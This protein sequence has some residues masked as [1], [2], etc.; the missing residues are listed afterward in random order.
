LGTYRTPLAV[1]AIS[2]ENI[3]AA[4][5][6]GAILHWDG[7]KWQS[8]PNPYTDNVRVQLR[9]IKALTEK[10]IWVVGSYESGEVVALHWDGNKWSDVPTLST[11]PGYVLSSVDA[12]SPGEI[13]A[14]G[15]TTNTEDMEVYSPT[16]GSVARFSSSSCV[17]TMNKITR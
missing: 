6:R 5:S 1:A 15:A 3:W 13:W 8:V 10:D 14:V 16:F 17:D 7:S 2:T 11:T 9:G 4:G 12:S